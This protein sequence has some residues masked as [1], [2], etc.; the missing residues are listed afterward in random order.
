MNPLDPTDIARAV[1]YVLTR[2][3][4][5]EAMGRAGR[6]AV[7]RRFN[8]AHE[9]RKLVSVYRQITSTTAAMSA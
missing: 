5:T 8:W 7:K 1:E 4:E 6:E 3:S 2:D 9:E